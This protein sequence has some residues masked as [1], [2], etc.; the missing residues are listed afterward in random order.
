MFRNLT[1]QIVLPPQ[2]DRIR[3]DWI[4][5]PLCVTLSDWPYKV[6]SLSSN[7]FQ[8][9]LLLARSWNRGRCWSWSWCR[10]GSSINHLDNRRRRGRNICAASELFRPLRKPISGSKSLL[11]MACLNLSCLC[12]LLYTRSLELVCFLS[13]VRFSACY[14]SF[15]LLLFEVVSTPLF[16]SQM[17]LTTRTYTIGFQFANWV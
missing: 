15:M 17:L 7:C 5:A 10:N 14:G 11:L 9:S 12:S 1:T 3:S 2:T 16:R 8:S 13:F 4:D 6:D